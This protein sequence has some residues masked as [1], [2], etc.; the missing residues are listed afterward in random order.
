MRQQT[1]QIKANDGRELFTR[2]WW[3]DAPTDRALVIAHGLGE[4]SGRYEALAAD[5]VQDGWSVH[6]IDHRGHGRSAGRR[7]D[8]ERFA[9][10]IEDLDRF[11]VRVQDSTGANCVV[12]LGHSMGGAIALAYALEHAQRL[13][14]L[15]L[16]GPALALPRSTP[17]LQVRLVHLLAAVAPGLGVLSLP[18]TAISRDPAVVAAYTQDPLVHHGRIPART[19]AELSAMM[20]SFPER[21]GALRLPVLVQHGTADSL[22]ELD[23]VRPLYDRLESADQTVLTYE[24][25]F[26]EIFNEPERARVIGDLKNWLDSRFGGGSS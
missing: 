14:G 1:D 5:L 13:H 3:P 7:A 10:L 21:I 20:E 18:P 23:A 15:A 8:I 4:H 2:H 11:V 16:S 17:D 24:G 12:L 25:F 26:H 19:V 22:V 6:A 9:L